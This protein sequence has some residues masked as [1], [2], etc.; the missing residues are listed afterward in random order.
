MAKP[1]A[2][3][4]DDSLEERISSEG[5]LQRRR[6]AERE[7]ARIPR[8]ELKP[9]NEKQRDAWTTINETIMGEGGAIVT[10]PLE[11]PIRFECDINSDLP[12]VLRYCGYAVVPHGTNERLF[13]QVVAGN[14]IVIPTTVA[15]WT[16]R[17]RTV[18][19]VC[20]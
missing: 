11:E 15:V 9:L 13:P 7:A 1:I 3:A 17:I 2:I 19:E 18:D 10:M 4:I 8:V 6:K 5:Y 20:A 14:T 12:E 16:L